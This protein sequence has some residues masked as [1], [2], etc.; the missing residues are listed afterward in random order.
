MQSLLLLG[1]EEIRQEQLI[2]VCCICQRHRTSMDTWEPL[3]ITEDIEA[4]ITHGFCPDCIKEYYPKISEKLDHP[5]SYKNRSE[6]Q[7]P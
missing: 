1:S 5:D 3:T 4:Y 6:S 2:T 7:S